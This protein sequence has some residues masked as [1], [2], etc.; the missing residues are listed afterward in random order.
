M[1]RLVE[2]AYGRPLHEEYTNVPHF[3]DIQIENGHDLEASPAEA[4]TPAPSVPTPPGAPANRP[5][6]AARRPFVPSS[7]PART[8]RCKLGK[9]SD[10]GRVRGP[11]SSLAHAQS[12]DSRPVALSTTRVEGPPGAGCGRTA[13]CCRGNAPRPRL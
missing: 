6:R 1:G 8:L 9:V 2:G 13:A 3:A 10:F 4:P 12:P 5:P 11:I 7:L